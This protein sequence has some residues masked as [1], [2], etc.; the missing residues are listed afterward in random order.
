M[1]GALGAFQG[2][3]INT[4]PLL[5]AAALIVML[6]TIIIYVIFQRQFIGALLQG[7]IKG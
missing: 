6:P 1:A 4:L 5:F 7:A 2:Q 3:Y